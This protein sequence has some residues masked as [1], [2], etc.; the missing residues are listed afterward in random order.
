MTVRGSAATATALLL[1][2]GCMT[3]PARQID[4]LF[5][6]YRGDATPGAAVRVIRD[7]EVVVS[8]HYG[9]A[10]IGAQQAVT[11][12]S[13]FRLASITKQFT[14]VSILKLIEQDVLTLD[15]VLTQV[16]PDFPAYGGSITIEHLLQHRS[17]LRDYE[18]LAPEGAT[19]QL[20]DADVL[21]IMK[22][23]DAGYFAPG[24]EYRYSNS[25]Y[26]VLAMIVEELTHRSFAEFLKTCIFEPAGM[27]RTVAFENGIS[28][29]TYRAMGYSVTDTR[30]ELADQSL[31]SAVLGDGGVYS[32]LEDLT[33]WDAALYEHDILSAASMKQMWTPALEGYGFGWRI[34]RFKGHVR[35]HHSGS[36]S[37]FRNYLQ[38][39]PEER[40]TVIVLTNRAEPDVTRLGETIADLY[41]P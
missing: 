40:L 14:A 32:S 5:E 8:R 3:D 6:G 22:Q 1:M 11:A 13:N 33:A 16:F 19:E 2:C 30:V 41:L 31:Y 4:E 9:M 39:F 20:R 27:S 35:Q 29:V 23:Q 37:G 17:G 36:T 28:T 15:T 25:G 34:D 26:A 10:N 21:E 7:G 38:R 18:P 12:S 24:S